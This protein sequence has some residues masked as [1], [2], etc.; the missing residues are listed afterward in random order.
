[1]PKISVIIPIY[2]VEKYIEKCISSILNQTYRDF[3]IILVDDHSPDSSS[4][5]AN[6]M[7]ELQTEIPYRIIYKKKNA[8]LSAA[9]NTGI[10]ISKGDF[11]LFIDSDDWIEKDM[12]RIMI[13]TSSSRNAEMVVSRVRQVYEENSNFHVLKSIKSG[14]ISGNEALS[15]LLKGKFPAHIF[16]ILF[17]KHLFEINKFPEGTVYEDSLTLP[18]LLFEA[19]RVCFIDD[20]LYNYLQRIGSITKSY[21]PHLIKVCEQIT[22][23]KNDFELLLH[24]NQKILLDRYIYFIYIV[25]VEHISILS[26]NYEKAKETL[27]YCRK[28]IEIIVLFR[29]FKQRPSKTVLLLLLLKI[30]PFQFYKRYN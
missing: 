7:L 16:K 11:L 20:I 14:V 12:L 6:N 10:E 5:L 4:T 3:E 18:Y 8:G 17:K 13:E 1:M 29:L 2:K 22:L 30:S 19:N 23:M 15:E 27:L 21:N 24:K 25:L 9:R 26:P 28:N